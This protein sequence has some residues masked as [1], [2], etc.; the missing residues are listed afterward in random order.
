V[1]RESVLDMPA[2]TNIK[3]YRSLKNK[4]FALSS[5]T[6]MKRGNHLVHVMGSDDI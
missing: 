6:I 5:S 1:V 4:H 3:I 2:T